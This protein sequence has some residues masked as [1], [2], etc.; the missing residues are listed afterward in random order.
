MDMDGYFERIGLD[1]CAATLRG[2]E[3][4]QSAQM[5][6]IAFENIDP[7]LGRVPDVSLAGIRDK[8]VA[9]GRGGY[10]FELNTLFGAALQAC[11]FRADRV[12]ARVRNGAPRGGQRS[13]LAWIVTVGGEEWL[14]D[15]GFGGAGAS[16]PLRVAA[17]AVQ[18]APTG[19]YRFVEDDGA[20]ELVLERET[21]EGWY[22]LFGFDRV[23]VSDVDVEAANFLCA[24]WERA[25]FP[26][27]LMLSRH[28]ERGRVSLLNTALRVESRG[29]VEKRTI[30]SEAELRAVLLD[31]FSLPGAAD[32]A[33]SIWR[34]LAELGHAAIR[35]R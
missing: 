20:G 4:L 23:P 29:E 9:G 15:T 3:E 27:N 22:A 13:H 30:A 35:P 11:G 10:C 26:S 18:E 16:V 1:G 2:L 8:L 17:R 5:R 28:H 31:L 25:P 14:A 7:L 21:P 12:L 34:R 24:R 33:P 32:L 19:R 6:A